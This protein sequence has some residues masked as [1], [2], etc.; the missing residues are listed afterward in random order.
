VQKI[1]ISRILFPEV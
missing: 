1:I